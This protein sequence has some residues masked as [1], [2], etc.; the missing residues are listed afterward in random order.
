[1][2]NK[3]QVVRLPQV[4]SKPATDRFSFIVKPTHSCNLRCQYCYVPDSAENGLMSSATLHKVMSQAAEVG[5]GKSIT[6]IWHGGEPLIA[7]LEFFREIASISHSLRETGLHIKNTIQTNGTLITDSLLD[8]IVKEHDFHIGLSIDGPVY[9]HDKIRPKADGSGSFNEIM[10]AIRMIRERGASEG[11]ECIGTGAICVIGKHNIDHLLEIYSL[12]KSLHINVKMNPL[13]V[14]GRATR[15]LTV[16]P[17][18]FAEAMCRLFDI[19]IDDD[20]SIKID[21]YESIMNSFLVGSP[22]SCHTS[23]TCTNTF[24]S[25]GPLG[26]IYPCGRFDGVREFHLGNINGPGGLVTALS[27]SLPKLLE[28]RPDNLDPSCMTCAYHSICHGG[29]MH[30]A[31]IQGNLMGRDPFCSLYK[32]LYGHILSKLHETLKQAESVEL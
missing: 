26:D 24:V 27:S 5:H 13:F 9:I 7:G 14:A 31:Y 3:S 18:E 21:P 2:E 23:P 25:I 15:D 12:F 16:T 32:K 11:R 17:D 22:S 10:N 20:D 19:W 6:F 8:F 28:S 29:C 4:C 1:M 30:N